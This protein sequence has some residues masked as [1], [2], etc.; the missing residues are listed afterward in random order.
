[1]KTRQELY[2]YCVETNM[3]TKEWC[4]MLK[5]FAMNQMNNWEKETVKYNNYYPVVVKL[6]WQVGLELMDILKNKCYEEVD[7]RDVLQVADQI[8]ENIATDLTNILKL[9]GDMDSIVKFRV[10]MWDEGVIYFGPLRD[11]NY[12]LFLDGGLMMTEGYNAYIRN[13]NNN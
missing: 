6:T 10:N 3:H 1:M 4:L 9:R 8:C 12:S 11:V 7:Y 2:T 5:K 13:R